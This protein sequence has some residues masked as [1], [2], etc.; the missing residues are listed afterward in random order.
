MWGEVIVV[1]RLGLSQQVGQ[2]AQRGGREGS[3]HVCG[4]AL[5]CLEGLLGV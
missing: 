5:L 2:L 3:Y 1:H 4:A